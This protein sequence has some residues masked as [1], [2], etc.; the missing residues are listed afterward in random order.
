[1]R[2]SDK[3]IER[4]SIW[5][6]AS[7]MCK[8]PQWSDLEARESDFVPKFWSS[9]PTSQLSQSCRPSDL[10]ASCFLVFA[11]SFLFSFFLFV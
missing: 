11:V 6:V 5:M 4:V 3:E 8:F 9:S 1:M 10:T 2:Q 7:I